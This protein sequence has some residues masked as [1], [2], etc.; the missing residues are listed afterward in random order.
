[1]LCGSLCALILW[2]QTKNENCSFSLE[3][4]SVTGI[5]KMIPRERS[6][7]GWIAMQEYLTFCKGRKQIEIKQIVPML[8]TRCYTVI[9]T[10]LKDELNVALSSIVFSFD[11]IP[12][13]P[14]STNSSSY[15]TYGLIFFML[16]VHF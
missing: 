11:V 10:T 2:K 9:L 6:V 8:S 5:K 4:D 15:P 12:A 7:T 14:S 16:Q 1:M 13:P 3:M